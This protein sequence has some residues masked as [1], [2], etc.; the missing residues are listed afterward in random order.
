VD[1]KDLSTFALNIAAQ[2][3]GNG[4]SADS[5]TKDAEVYY[6][7]LTGVADGRSAD[8]ACIAD[9]IGILR[10]ASSHSGTPEWLASVTEW[11]HRHDAVLVRASNAAV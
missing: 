6:Q 1:N 8:A 5:V 10:N 11:F 4:A 7:W 2:R 9:A 3:R